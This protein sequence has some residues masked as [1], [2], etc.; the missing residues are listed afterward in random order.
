MLR[1]VNAILQNSNLKDR[2]KKSCV[3]LRI[4]KTNKFSLKVE[5]PI[6]GVSDWEVREAISATVSDGWENAQEGGE[7][8]WSQ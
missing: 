6:A 3:V 8:S 7:S 2:E 4:K 5:I 1:V